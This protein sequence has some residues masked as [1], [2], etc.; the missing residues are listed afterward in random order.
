MDDDDD[1]FD[2]LDDEDDEEAFEQ[3]VGVFNYCP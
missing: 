3:D 1:D 2:D